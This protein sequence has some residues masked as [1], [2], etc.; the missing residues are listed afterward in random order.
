MQG[1]Y[2]EIVSQGRL[3]AACIR[4]SD[5]AATNDT[6]KSLEKSVP[7]AA[8]KS[9]GNLK[10]LERRYHLLYLKAI[11]VQCVFET[12]LARKESSVSKCVTNINHFL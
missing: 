2:R 1:L 9:D 12:L 6:N 11:E 3:V 4:S 5:T 8:R 10:A 7:S